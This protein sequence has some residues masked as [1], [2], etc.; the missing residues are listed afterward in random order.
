MA[1][2]ERQEL[3]HQISLD[4]ISVPPRPA[5]QPSS[6]PFPEA[7]REGDRGHP[8]G[9]LWSEVYRRK[10]WL[11]CQLPPSNQK[12]KEFIVFRVTAAETEGSEAEIQCSVI[13]TRGKRQGRIFSFSVVTL[14]GSSSMKL[15]QQHPHEGKHSNK[16]SQHHVLKPKFKTNGN[17]NSFFPV[18]KPTVFQADRICAV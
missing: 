11:V 16:Y 1:G 5:S 10:M 12:N 17:P 13:S 2:K 3:P 15:Q 4:Q 8:V 6:Q 7:L 18:F 14:A 9:M